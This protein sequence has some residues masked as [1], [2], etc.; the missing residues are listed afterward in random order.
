MK[1][2]TLL[3]LFVLSMAFKGFSQEDTL[4]V[5]VAKTQTLLE[6]MLSS[7]GYMLKKEVIPAGTFRSYAL[8]VVKVSNLETFQ[9]FSGIRITQGFPAGTLSKQGISVKTYLDSKEVDNLLAT[10]AYMSTITKMQ[11]FPA[12]YTEIF[13]NSLGGS[14]LVLYIAQPTP[15][16]K[17]WG[18]AYQINMNVNKSFT[19]LY[20][21]DIETLSKLLTEAKAKF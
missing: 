6:E 7:T 11:S 8:D 19:N 13:F 2:Y 16:T 5:P 3:V 21:N 14:Q 4:I 1:K 20:I 18:L 12:N 9:T 15:T 17:K 10:L